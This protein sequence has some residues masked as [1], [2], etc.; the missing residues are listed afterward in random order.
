MNNQSQYHNQQFNENYPDGMENY[1]W[2]H[3]RNK[4]LL[5]ELKKN[6]DTNK[7][8]LEIGC[9]KGL[10]ISYLRVNGVNVFGS[11]LGSPNVL[12][13]MKNYIFTDKD[14]FDLPFEFRESIEV[15]LLLDVLE[16]IENP[17]AFLENVLDKF[18]N[19]S[20]I[21]I[22]VPSRSELWSS[23][24]IKYGHF[25]RYDLLS[26]KALFNPSKLQAST[27]KYL[28]HC[29]YLPALYKAKTSGVRNEK[30]NPPT[31][32]MKILIH[33]FLSFILYLDY[34][35]FPKK[36]VGTSILC[37]LEKTDVESKENS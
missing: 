27:I 35:L 6:N 10:V 32:K 23:Y 11:E 20:K 13:N 25:K 30:L 36:M 34:K 1:F 22:S 8:I 7:K 16:H 2:T 37:I 5:S 3:A 12:T 14:C 28:F 19:F 21:Y 17:S 31:T 4:I 33:R 15:L 18:P 9:A 26:T 29:L 24:D